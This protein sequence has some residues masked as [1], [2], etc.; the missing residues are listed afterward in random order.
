MLKTQK[1]IEILHLII[2]FGHMINLKLMKM[3]IVKQ[4]L[5]QNMLINK[6]YSIQ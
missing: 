2:H 1:K 6:W 5:V 3:D 4:F